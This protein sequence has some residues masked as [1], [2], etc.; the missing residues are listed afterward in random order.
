MDDSYHRREK[1]SLSTLGIILT[2]WG[3]LVLG[4]GIWAEIDADSF[5]RHTSTATW[6]PLA[7]V[8]SL[9]LAAFAFGLWLVL[10]W[11]VGI[12]LSVIQPATSLA[13]VFTNAWLIKIDV[14]RYSEGQNIAFGPLADSNQFAALCWNTAIGT[15]IALY[16]IYAAIRN[17]VWRRNH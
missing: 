2:F 12:E 14:M 11:I 10:A 9:G 16:A 3:A 1:R 13:V 6:I 15:A 4:I 17:Y 5:V 8:L 7:V